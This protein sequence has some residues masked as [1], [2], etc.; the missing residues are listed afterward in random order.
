MMV[1]ENGRGP[2]R[3]LMRWCLVSDG[4]SGSVQSRE[5]IAQL[6]HSDPS[7]LSLSREISK[8]SGEIRF[9]GF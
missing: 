3:L 6:S 8:E 7:S 1:E 2:G 9:E 4:R 5:R